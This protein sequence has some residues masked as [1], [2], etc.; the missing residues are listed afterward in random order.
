[1]ERAAFL[2]NEP[3]RRGGPPPGAL[4][5]EAGA[6]PRGTGGLPPDA[7]GGATPGARG[8]GARGEARA[9]DAGAETSAT[10][11]DP[12]RARRA[13]LSQFP[14]KDNSS[15]RKASKSA[16]EV[17]GNT[18]IKVNRNKLRIVYVL[19]GIA[20]LVVFLTGL[21][22]WRTFAANWVFSRMERSVAEFWAHNDSKDVKFFHKC[23][24]GFWADALTVH[25]LQGMEYF[26]SKVTSEDFCE[27]DTAA[28]AIYT[29]SY[30]SPFGEESTRLVEKNRAR[31]Q[32]SA[33]AHHGHDPCWLP[34]V[35]EESKVIDIRWGSSVFP[36]PWKRFLD[37]HQLRGGT[38]FR[39]LR[40]A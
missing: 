33:S 24:Q 6:H 3:P 2:S 16:H 39:V 12:P 8:P 7:P 17:R 5:C 31:I 10:A 38:H 36:S 23:F 32:E 11:F 18:K 26:F 25:K 40:L 20:A 34:E 14:E 1:M 37:S 15:T 4:G 13:R 19:S 21:L 35:L 9:F 27:A 29:L 28:L 22:G 30:E